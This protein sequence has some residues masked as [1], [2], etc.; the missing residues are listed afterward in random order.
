L[1]NVKVRA[2]ET[3][4]DRFQSF[5]RLVVESRDV[6][7]LRWG[8][9]VDCPEAYYVVLVAIARPAAWSWPRV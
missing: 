5:N 1:I 6:R 8:G 4:N 2:P 3:M 7:D 9:G